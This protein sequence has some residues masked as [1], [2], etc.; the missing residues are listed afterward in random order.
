MNTKQLL[1]RLIKTAKGQRKYFIASIF[2]CLVSVT[3]SLLQPFVIGKAVDSMIG[4]DNINYDQILKQIGF[5]AGITMIGFASNWLLSFVTNKLSFATTTQLRNEVF[6]HYNSIPLSTLDSM[7]NGD[8]MARV[9]TDIENI[10]SGLL[11]G[12]AQL[13]SGIA[14]IIGTLGLMLYINFWISLVVIVLTP[15]SLVIA[16]VIAKHTRNQF[17]QQAEQQ[18]KL[19][20]YSA[21]AIDGIKTIQLY[22]S[23]QP[24]QDGFVNINN[25]LYHAGVRAQFYSSLTNPCTRFVNNLVYATVGVAGACIGFSM[26]LITAGGLTTFLMYSTQYT[27]PFNEISG[28]V[29]ELQSALASARRVYAFL[30]L[31]AEH[32]GDTIIENSDGS[33]AF[34]NVDFAYNCDHP[35][36]SNLNLDIQPGQKVAIVGPTGCGK[37]TLIN[38][39][40]RF[41]D[42]NNGNITISGYDINKCKRSSL[43]S[44]FAMVLQDTWLF[45]GTIKDNISFGKPNATIQEIEQ[46]AISSGANHFIMAMP[47]GYDTIIYNNGSNLSQGQRQLL[48]ISRVFLLS[49]QILILDEATSNIDTRTEQKIDIAFDKLKKNRTSFVVAHRLST[50]RNA[51]LILVMKDGNIIET[52]NHEN[53]LLRGGF[54]SELYNSQFS[55][56]K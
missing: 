54:Y 14:T 48:C 12:Y 13:L 55:N 16:A 38:L 28:V 37:T 42:V 51:D 24:T 45:N 17:R 10:S 53:L 47:D 50:I 49:P 6:A 2:F 40:M 21:E 33:V 11:Q 7:S 32:D 19:M 30:A 15:L 18:G 4:V 8:L 56:D 46:A 43:R 26:G 27:K 3:A 5:L 41:Y 20:G 34:N 31:E 39:L 36:I 1:L 22:D 44:N 35:L 25:N 52:G 29:A 23:Q 9:G